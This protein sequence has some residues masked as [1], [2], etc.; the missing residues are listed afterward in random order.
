M[1][2]IR[3]RSYNT[4]TRALPDT[5]IAIYTYIATHSPYIQLR[6]CILSN[7]SQIRPSTQPDGDFE[8][9]NLLM[10]ATLKLLNSS[11]A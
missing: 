5:Y 1:I 10:I 8:K 11:C 9:L 2:A 7:V 3:I 4:G 6:I